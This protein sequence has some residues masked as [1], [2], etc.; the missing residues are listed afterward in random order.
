MRNSL[1]CQNR[2]ARPAAAAAALALFATLLLVGCAANPAKQNLTEG[3]AA[4]EQKKFDEAITKANAVLLQ[5]SPGQQAQGAAEA[6][7]LKGRVLEEQV[8][9]TPHESK[10]NLQAARTEYI[11]A[12]SSNPPPRLEPLIRTSLGNVAYFQDDYTTAIEQWAA[13]YPRLESPDVRS[14]VIY[15]IGLSQQRLGRFEQA[16]QTFAR[17]QQEFPNTIPAQRARE[18]Q[19]ARQFYVQL[20]TFAS[21]ASADQTSNRLRQQGVAPVRV[22]DAQGRHLIRV[23]PIAS[24]PQ[25]QLTRQRFL[26]QYPDAFIVP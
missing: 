18:H 12:L 11:Q 25:A 15:R 1:F 14:W 21:A 23:G 20:A 26:S 6:H 2:R 7:Y 5:S 19:G 16:D 13:A 17:V 4:L 24:Y 10:V 3:Y 8:A 22:T 9:A